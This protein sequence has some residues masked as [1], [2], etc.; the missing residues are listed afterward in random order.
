M[1]SQARQNLAG[2]QSRLG[3][4]LGKTGYP[5]NHRGHATSSG[6]HS[7][8]AIFLAGCPCTGQEF[9]SMHLHLPT[10]PG[11]I[12]TGVCGPQVA[13]W[14]KRLKS[15]ITARQHV[16]KSR[17][18]APLELLLATNRQWVAILVAESPIGFKPHVPPTNGKGEQLVRQVAPGLSRPNASPPHCTATAASG[19]P[20][21][22][23]PTCGSRRS[24]FHAMAMA[25]AGMHM[26]K[27]SLFSS[28]AS[29][30]L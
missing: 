27:S 9:V 25:F 1:I 3:R 14:E 19:G 22:R 4:L 23:P 5:Y 17:R 11:H 16:T 15:S 30:S 21:G 29:I 2:P 10:I 13:E 8:R 18:P 7:C 26:C 20:W 28:K 6:D 24:K 12:V